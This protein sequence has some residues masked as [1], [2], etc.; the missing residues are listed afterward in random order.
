VLRA[1]A[2]VAGIP[3]WIIFNS[4]PYAAHADPTEAEL[5]WQAFTA[6]AYG[7]SGVLYYCYWDPAMTD[8]GDWAN[9]LGGSIIQV[10]SCTRVVSRVLTPFS[11]IKRITIGTET[12]A[13]D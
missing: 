4:M 6:L 11:F 12:G 8:P 1:Q 5:R 13:A 3:F 7:T 2:G 9:Q 10:Y